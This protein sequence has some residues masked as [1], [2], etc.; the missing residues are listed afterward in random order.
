[1]ACAPAGGC[2]GIHASYRRFDDVCA[3][4]AGV[5][6]IRRG[7]RPAFHCHMR[8]NQYAAGVDFIT[9]RS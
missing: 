3:D 4:R 9:R 8:N 5:V 2:G 6:S 7:N 1:M